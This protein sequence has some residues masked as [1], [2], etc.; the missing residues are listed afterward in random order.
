[1][2]QRR[3]KIWSPNDCNT[4]RSEK[5]EG[6]WQEFVTLQF[7]CDRYTKSVEMKIITTFF[8]ILLSVSV[9]QAQFVDDFSDGDFS[10]NPSWAGDVDRFRI[11][12]GELQL[13][14]QSAGSSNLSYLQASVP[15]ST[16][17][18]T[19]WEFSVHLEF[20]PSSSNYA[21]I[22]LA[23]AG[24][25]LSTNPQGY[26]VKIGGISGSDDA[27]ELYRQDEASAEI[28]I[29]GTTGGVGSNPAR[30]RVRV[31]RNA[32]GQWALWADYSVGSDYQLEGEATDTTYPFGSFLGVVCRYTA[33]RNEDFFF[34]D[35][36]V[37]PLYV[38]TDPPVVTTVEV[39]SATELRVAFNE[40]LDVA[41]S[42]NTENYSVPGV[43]NPVTAT[44]AE[45]FTEVNLSFSV[46]FVSG[47]SYTLQTNQIRDEAGNAGGVYENEFI[48]YDVQPAEEY[49]VLID[50]IMADPT[51]AVLL[52][53]AEYVELFNTSGKIIDLEGFGFSS[54]AAPKIL[55]H[56]LLFP[57]KYVILCDEDDAGDFQAYGE[58]VA[59]SG[60]PAL[61]NSHDELT[62][63]DKD[64]N[65]I[66]YLYYSDNW[67]GND[68]KAEGGWSLEMIN[69]LSPC[70]DAGNWSAT[71]DLSG[72]TPGRANSLLNAVENADGAQLL[73]AFVSND[74]LY[75]VVLTFDRA[76]DEN[77]ASQVNNFSIDN[78][79]AI[80]NATVQFPSKKQVLLT[81][82]TP[83]LPGITY[84]VTALDELNDCTGNVQGEPHTARF[85]VPEE[86]A[87]KDLV[88][89][90]I[91]FNPETGGSDFLELYNRSDKIFDIGDFVVG[92][93]HPAGDSTV[94]S[95][96]SHLLI[97]PKDF[98]VITENAGDIL[99]RYT[100]GHPGR[101]IENPLPA[102]A[103][104]YGNVTLY[105]LGAQGAV[106]IDT[107]DYDE[108][109]HHVLLDDKNGV[110]LERI[111]TS[112]ATND[113]NNWHS[114]SRQSGYGTPTDKNSQ[115]V[116][117]QFD[118]SDVFE[119]N[120]HVFS[121][122]NDGHEDFLLIKYSAEKS[123]YLATV[124]VFDAEGRLVK[125]LSNNELLGRQGTLKWD[126]DN[127]AG[128][129]VHTGIYVIW[130]Q[131][132]SPEGDV[133]VFKK[134]CVVAGNF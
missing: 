39:L 21:K 50:E 92:N 58:V 49:D 112:V 14:D 79:M 82:S 117:I 54:G 52:P 1:M 103:N 75:E 114:A 70:V 48:Y 34:D 125:G 86:A 62:L 91:L 47:Q 7:S 118:V 9:I 97:F 129:K 55:P 109:Y 105:R 101:L 44:L 20:A 15:T 110:S 64:G 41:S 73:T 81:V 134:T 69:P 108:D 132:F 19:T 25:D 51:P 90:E 121:P 93:F 24:S 37:D 63:T 122:D 78:A 32:A 61:T 107:F 77:T 116:D 128:Q 84:R 71:N 83:F 22:Y 60:F 2:K 42:E 40:P 12:G 29:K 11:S 115:S 53:E 111:S 10:N 120:N 89:N 88:I 59:V 38:D 3:N 8:S 130:M 67:Y 17:D 127:D 94:T 72:G 100:V 45:N 23:A 68:E 102:F 16:G 74:D 26:F 87:P 35:F 133:Q 106:I 98:V 46:P 80:V 4:F 96:Q 119:L 28:L 18:S 66:H 56:F 123:G 85:G 27:I 57:G 113:R 99:N 43:G 6:E 124:K 36:Y 13:F 131:I 104:E 33:T 31:T 5:Q 126:G 65:I 76:L 95:I 30:A